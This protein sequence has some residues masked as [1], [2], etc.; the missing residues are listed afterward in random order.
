MIAAGLPGTICYLSPWQN[1]EAF[2]SIFVLRDIRGSNSMSFSTTR[3]VHAR[4]SSAPRPTERCAMTPSRSTQ[5]MLHE[6]PGFRRDSL[7]IAN[8]VK[9]SS[10]FESSGVTSCS[11]FGNANRLCEP[12]PSG[13]PVQARKT[14]RGILHARELRYLSR[15]Q[16]FD[17]QE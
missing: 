11:R 3:V 8:I 5:I 1:K 4:S 12:G 17:D 6:I 15:I 10:H 7:R 13:R 9:L 14:E 2:T 16:L